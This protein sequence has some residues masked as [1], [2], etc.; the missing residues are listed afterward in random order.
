MIVSNITNYFNTDYALSFIGISIINVEP[1]P[2]LLSR[3]IVKPSV[4]A[5]CFT[6]DKPRPVD[7][8]FLSLD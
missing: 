5:I 3:S 4:S 2:N 7:F 8:T 1:S 6:I